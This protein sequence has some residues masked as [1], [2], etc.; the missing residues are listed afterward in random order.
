MM[1]FVRQNL[2]LLIPVFVLWL[3]LL[4]LGLRDLLPRRAEEVTGGSKLLW[5]LVIVFIGTFGPLIYF[6][7]GRKRE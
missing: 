1:D 4:I 5:G 7:F 6:A 3:V 2:P